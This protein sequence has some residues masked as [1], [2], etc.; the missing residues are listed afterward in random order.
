MIAIRLTPPYRGTKP[1]APPLWAIPQYLDLR[2]S[3]SEG[4]APDPRGTLDRYPDPGVSH[5]MGPQ[6]GDLERSECHGEPKHRQK[7]A[8]IGPFWTGILGHP[9]GKPTTLDRGYKGV[10]Q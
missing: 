5:E 7:E 6:I 8:Q 1:V 3:L 10:S 9:T 4:R 2:G